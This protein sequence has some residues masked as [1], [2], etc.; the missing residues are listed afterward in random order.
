TIVSAESIPGATKLLRLEVDIGSEVR[1]VCAG[2]AEYY[3]PEELV[4]TKIVLVANLQ[5]RKMRGVE[6]N[7]MIV[8]A[9]VGEQGKPVLVTFKEEVPNGS[10]LK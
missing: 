3:K 6:S 9:S 7:G 1:Q 4:G 10:R 2:I 5:P 8:A